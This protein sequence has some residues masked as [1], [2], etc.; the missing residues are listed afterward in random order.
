M[1]ILVCFLLIKKKILPPGRF[2]FKRGIFCIVREAGKSKVKG[3]R[4]LLGHTDAGEDSAESQDSARC[5]TV[6]IKKKPER[7]LSNKATPEIT[8][9]LLIH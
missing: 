2:F 9:F 6:N 8:H 1:S 5:H 3:H 4:L 7:S